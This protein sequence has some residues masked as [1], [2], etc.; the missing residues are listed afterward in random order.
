MRVFISIDM[1]GVAGVAT[2][3]QT[4]RGGNGYPR[5]QR[6]MTAE[7][8][9]AIRG[10]FDAGAD[11]VVIND[12]HGTM[13]NLLQDE[14]DPYAQVVIGA[15]K[16]LSMMQ[17]ITPGDAVAFFV[18]YHASAGD[19]G[20][21][22]HSFSGN[23]TQI[24]L[25]GHPVGELEINGL[26]AASLGVPVGLVTGDD[27]VCAAAEKAFPGA[28]VVAVKEAAGFQSASS[29]HPTVAAERIRLAAHEAVI[30]CAELACR[31][32][33]DTIRVEI[34]FASPL[35]CDYAMSVPEARRVGGRTMER[36][37]RSAT[38]L[39]R[40]ISACVYLTSNAARETAAV[41]MRR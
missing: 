20:T 37:V 32:V 28:Q 4:V 22:A 34:D 15:P 7:A 1:E 24:R 35:A 18:G 36:E 9:A 11:E 5:A 12:S 31:Q 29:L 40:L 25:D 2:L 13:D 26:Y 3:D 19:Q 38:D 39:L 10:A 21:L 23:F 33:P 16:A 30:T 6:L 8:N 41:A 17:G 27:I 14:L